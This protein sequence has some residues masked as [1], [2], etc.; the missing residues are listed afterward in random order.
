MSGGAK[1]NP[2]NMLSGD[3]DAHT[4]SCPEPSVFSSCRAATRLQ[5]V[6]IRFFTDVLVGPVGIGK[7]TVTENLGFLS[8]TRSLI[9]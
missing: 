1:R 7:H 8:R 4:Q 9:K 5:V 2:S 3:N 6:M